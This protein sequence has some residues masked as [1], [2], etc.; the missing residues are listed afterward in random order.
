MTMIRYIAGV[1]LFL[2][3]RQLAFAQTEAGPAYFWVTFTSKENTP[4]STDRPE[5]FLSERALQR[6]RAHGRSVTQADLPVDPAFLDSLRDRGARI[7]HTS[8]WFNAAT[9]LVERDSLP[10]LQ[11]FSFVDSISYV[12]RYL[13]FTRKGGGSALVLQDSVTLD[14]L[15]DFPYGYATPQI[16]ILRGDS[17]HQRGFNGK[18]KLI[19]VLD[20]GFTNVDVLP[21]FKK[22]RQ[23]GGLL[24]TRDFVE[25]D[26][27]PFEGSTHGTQVL[28]LMAADIPHLLVGTAPGADY[29]CIKTEDTR[30]E[31]R[32]EECN[33]IAGVEYADSAGVDIINASLGYTTFNDQTMNYR[34][35][36]LDG[37]TALASQAADLA[38]ERGMIVVVSA[39]NEGNS[40][41]KYIG[42]PSDAQG[43]LAIAA[44]TL[45]GTRASFSSEGP[46]A[47]GRV[48]PDLA[49]PGQ[50]VA[51]ASPDSY[52]VMAGS[53]TSFAAPI[54]SGLIASLWQAFPEAT[55]TEIVEALRRSA[56]QS[57]APDGLLGYGIPDFDRAFRLLA[58]QE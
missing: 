18:G 6:R 5:A 15:A 38:F 22:L 47:D 13:Q 53:G 32:L 19:G 23:R 31:Y 2:L 27:L 3:C 57:E 49:A 55:N 26:S 34:Y 43:A 25:G 50:F 41:W 39:G 29:L 10:R 28:S 14:T 24:A 58:N 21:F 1:F 40:D 16:G 12:G 52:Q 45:R 42:V 46:A 51:V 48:K 11:A 30:G 36:Q 37:R 9:V 33:W 4:F 17:L 35:E 8:R 7:H 56:H 20:G 44:T 54:M